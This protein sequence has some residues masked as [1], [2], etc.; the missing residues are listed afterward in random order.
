MQLSFIA[1]KESVGDNDVCT[2]CLFFLNDGNQAYVNEPVWMGELSA[3]KSEESMSLDV[4]S[5]ARTNLTGCLYVS[6]VEVE[7]V[8]CYWTYI[9]VAKMPVGLA[10]TVRRRLCSRNHLYRKE[11]VRLSRHRNPTVFV[12]ST[13][14][15]LDWNLDPIDSVAS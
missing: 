7:R 9:C 1:F 14:R 15:H 4:T 6:D 3:G 8:R 2:L 13:G 11:R 10:F 5:N 12:R